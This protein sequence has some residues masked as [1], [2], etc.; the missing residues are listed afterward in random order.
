VENSR[1]NPPWTID[2]MN[3]ACFLV[4]GKNGRAL[5]Y[6]YFENE[7][8]RRAAANPL[9]KDEARRIFERTTKH[10]PR[11]RL[12]IRQRTRVSDQYPQK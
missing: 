9:I 3:A 6:F 8:G 12:T 11:I 5:G 10:R 4:R 7:P 2:E 1:L